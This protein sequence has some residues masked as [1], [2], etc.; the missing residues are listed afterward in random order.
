MEQN[1]K[2]RVHFEVLLACS[3]QC[4]SSDILCCCCIVQYKLKLPKRGGIGDIK[5]ELGILCGVEASH[6]AVVDVYNGRFHRIY[7][8]RDPLTHIMDKVC[9]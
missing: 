5:K 3:Q 9:V 4:M 1:Y 2:K 6:L 8:D 7:T